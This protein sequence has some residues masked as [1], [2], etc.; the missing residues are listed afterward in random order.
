MTS[1]G[2][3]GRCEVGR[4]LT[5]TLRTPNKVTFKKILFATDFSSFSNAALP[6]A[7]GISH[8]CGSK[9]CVAHVVSEKAYLFIGSEDYPRPKE[10]I[11]A[12][13][14]ETYL[15]NSP[16]EMLSSVR[17]IPD[18]LFRLIHDNQID[19]LILG[20]RGR[21]GVPK[22][23]LGSVAEK[24]FREASIPVL[25][26]GLKVSLQQTNV[27]DFG[28]IVVATDFGDES[29][30]AIGYAL[31]LTKE[32]HSHLSFLHVL[33]QLQP[34]TLDIEPL[35]DLAIRRMQGFVPSD[36]DLWFRPEYFVE[37]GSVEKE[38]VKFSKERSSDLIVLGIRAPEHALTAVSHL[39]HSQAE[40]IVA[41]ATCP[42]LTVR[43]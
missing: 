14:V 2:R 30:A 1:Y 8:H 11:D 7:L 36:A 17:D 34:R 6:Y 21:S 10:Q 23:L 22:L 39:A 33:W 12:T 41:H 25:T 4:R 43:G 38:V 24:I 29:A 35:A 28:Q 37:W 18:F 15:K 20:T 42:V 5:K 27:A 32:Y 31:S 13:L 3:I 19:L 26:V 16:H 9:L 40:H